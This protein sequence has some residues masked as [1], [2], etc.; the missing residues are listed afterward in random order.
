MGHAMMHDDMRGN[1]LIWIMSKLINFIAAGDGVYHQV[2]TTPETGSVPVSSVIG[3]N[4]KTLLE[5][6]AEIEKELNAWLN[7]LPSTFWP[8][9][10]LDHRQRVSSTNAG[11]DSSFSEIWC[12]NSSC[13]KIIRC[14][15]FSS[16]KHSQN[17]VQHQLC[18]SIIWQGF[19][20]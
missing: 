9:A 3:V 4:Q 1:A 17:C 14:N 6:W 10:R 18:S 19:Y 16:S 7:G 13:G 8:C 11:L 5:R 12:T 2:A 15:Y 20:C